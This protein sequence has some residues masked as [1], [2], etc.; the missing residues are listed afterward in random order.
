MMTYHQSS[1]VETVVATLT[2][3]VLDTQIVPS[4][5]KNSHMQTKN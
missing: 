2:Q 1:K 5:N 3:I 4:K